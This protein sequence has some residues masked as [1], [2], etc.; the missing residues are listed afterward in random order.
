M[1]SD[2]DKFVVPLAD[3]AQVEAVYYG[4]GTLCL[5]SQVGCAVGC[6]FCASGADGFRRNLDAAE[7]LAQLAVARSRGHHPARL[8][9][10]GVGE[11][12]HNLAAEAAYVAAACRQGLPVSLTTTGAPLTRLAD[13]LMLEHNGLMFS[14]HAGRSETHRRLV[15]AGPP[16]EAFWLALGSLW[17]RLSR[18]R[19]RLVGINYLL[20]EGANDGEEELAAFLERLRPFPEV[21]VHLLTCNP[22]A[23]SPFHGA[24]AAIVDAWHGRLV[25]AG[26]HARRANRWR[27]R[28][29]GGCG[30]LVARS[31]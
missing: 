9:V 1:E 29:E 22:V 7:M 2:N 30:T 3:G 25:A 21:T 6:P 26:V 24:G 16:F 14:V 28:L 17:P 23:G 20:L 13:A 12:L 27:R 11:P 10:S 4:S 15:P 18:R 19:R 5:S 31:R 8:T